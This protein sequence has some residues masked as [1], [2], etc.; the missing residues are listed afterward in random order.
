M[1][2][3][4]KSCFLRDL[5]SFQGTNDSISNTPLRVG[6]P[7]GAERSTIL[8]FRQ[9]PPHFA[10]TECCSTWPVHPSFPWKLLQVH[11]NQRQPAN[12]RQ[13]SSGGISSHGRRF[14]SDTRILWVSLLTVKSRNCLAASGFAH[15]FTMAAAVRKGRGSLLG[16][17]IIP[18]QLPQ[19]AGPG[20]T[21]PW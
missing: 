20:R 21:P 6:Q 11:L 13:S 4:G 3:T 1:S 5:F 7:Y 14:K 15:P 9:S 12:G 18:R 10:G 19:T 17:N 8:V 2:S 16:I